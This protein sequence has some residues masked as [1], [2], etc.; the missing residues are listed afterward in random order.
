MCRSGQNLV[1]V[2]VR[3]LG[4]LRTL[5]SPEPGVNPASGPGPLNSPGTPLRKL[6]AHS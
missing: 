6:T 5:R 4:S 2:P 3:D 1:L